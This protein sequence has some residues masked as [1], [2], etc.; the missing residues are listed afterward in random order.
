MS[1]QSL[2]DPR[3]SFSPG[4]AHDNSL[5][6]KA[7][8]FFFKYRGYTPVPFVAILVFFASPSWNL[9]FI[10]FTVMAIGEGIRLWAMSYMEGIARSRTIRVNQL[11]TSGPYRFVRNPLYLGNLLLYG[12]AAIIGNI[13]MP[14]FLLLAMLYFAIQYILIVD[15]EEKVLMETFG[16]T[17]QKYRSEIPRFIPGLSVYN[18]SSEIT[19][20]IQKAFKSE[21]SSLIGFAAIVLFFL[22]RLISG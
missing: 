2:S 21:K 1:H 14:Y 9:F 18:A 3:Q 8:K 15:A 13:W 16:E 10:G 4:T 11:V 19:P 20:H 17:Y 7:G 5:L 6:Q 12:G 22:F